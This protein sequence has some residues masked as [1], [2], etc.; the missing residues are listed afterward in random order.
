M[1]LKPLPKILYIDDNDDAR[2]LVGRLMLGRYIMLEARDP[3]VGIQ[4]A[5]ETQP[6]LILLDL[7]LPNMDGMDV[8][9]YLRSIL[10]P[11]TPILALTAEYTPDIR[12]HGLA[13]GF[14]G[15]MTKPIDI[16]KFFQQIDASL[17][18]KRARLSGETN[19]TI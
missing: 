18:E 8:A 14:S 16:D 10:E 17:N 9:F 11:G 7:N 19:Q 4:L 1:P 6:D 2:L 13:V 12:E 3:I 5:K 15:F